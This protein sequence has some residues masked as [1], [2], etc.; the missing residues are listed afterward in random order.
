MIHGIGVLLGHGAGV[1]LG[2][3][4]GVLLGHGVGEV[5]VG[6]LVRYGD[7]LTGHGVPV[8]TGR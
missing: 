7:I 2:H 6:V 5:P 4:A 8:E 3:G 1:L